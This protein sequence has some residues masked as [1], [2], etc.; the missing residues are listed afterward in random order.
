MNLLEMLMSAGGNAAVGQLGSRFGLDENQTMAAL[1]QLVPALGGGLQRNIAAEGGLDN[2][3]GALSGGNHGQYIDNPELVHSEETTA[4]GNGIL[5]HLLGSKDASR[6]LA[7]QASAQT[8]IGADVLKQMLPVVA[9][10]GMGSLSKQ[11]AAGGFLGGQ[12]A[13]AQADGL[14]GMLTP[15]LD[16]NHDGSVA[17]DVV[18]MIGRFMSN[19]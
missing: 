11:S 2:L 13:P 7:A 8:G 16:S 9:T 1:Q 6:E 19:R 17:D 18:G 12:G 5:G 4:E 3:L 10:M 15:L 14:L